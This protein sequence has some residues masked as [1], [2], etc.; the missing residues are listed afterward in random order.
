MKIKNRIP[1]QVTVTIDL[2]EEEILSDMLDELGVIETLARL[3]T[4]LSQHAAKTTL[5]LGSERRQALGA[6]EEI[7]AIMRRAVGATP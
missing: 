4:A 1:A 7:L 5:R 3:Q 6:S 2:P